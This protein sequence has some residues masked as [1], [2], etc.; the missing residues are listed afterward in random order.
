MMRHMTI[1]NPIYTFRVECTRILLLSLYTQ[2]VGV[3]CTG[4]F[5]NDSEHFWVVCVMC[6][7]VFNKTMY[8]LHTKRWCKLAAALGHRTLFH[9]LLCQKSNGNECWIAKCVSCKLNFLQHGIRNS[10]KCICSCLSL[11]P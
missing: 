7:L 8:T 4:T 2:F 3:E 11:F 9:P 5:C 6:Q 10:L 1:W